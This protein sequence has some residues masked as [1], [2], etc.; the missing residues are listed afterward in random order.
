MNFEKNS[1]GY[2]RNNPL[3]YVTKCDELRGDEHCGD[4]GRLGFFGITTAKLVTT[5]FVTVKLVTAKLVTA[6]LA[7]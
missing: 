4:K 7:P 1:T 5:K 2:V 3:Q 6:K